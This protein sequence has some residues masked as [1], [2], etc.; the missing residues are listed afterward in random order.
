M[1]ANTH[2]MMFA[3]RGSFVAHVRVGLANGMNGQPCG[4]T[5]DLVAMRYSELAA[6]ARWVGLLAVVAKVA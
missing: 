3:G 2:E 6:R 4:A 5:Y 1:R